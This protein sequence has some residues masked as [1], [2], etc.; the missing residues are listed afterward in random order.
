[1]FVRFVIFL[2]FSIFFSILGRNL[3]QIVLYLA[4]GDYHGFHSPVDWKMEKRLHVHGHMLSVSKAAANLV[5]GL[6]AI[7]ER[8]V[9][10]GTWKGGAMFYSPVA[11]TNVG[12][13]SI[14]NDP[15]VVTNVLG[16]RPATQEQSWKTYQEP[17]E[18]KKGDEIGFFHL[19]STIVMVFESEEDFE[20][21]CKEGEKVRLGEPL[22]VVG[23]RKPSP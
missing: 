14:R 19:G 8:V 11:A 7:N 22:G 18:V 20:F 9:L 15:A 5:P 16:K 4:P 3:Y 10:K 2:K 17:I 21:C 6:F 12:N 1:M 23:G 13:I